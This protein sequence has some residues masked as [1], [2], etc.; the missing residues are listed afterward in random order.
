M[1]IVTLQSRLM[2]HPAF[3]SGCNCFVSTLI[4][5]R[6]P[7]DS[8]CFSDVRSLHSVLQTAQRTS[9]RPVILSRLRSSPVPSIGPIPT[10]DQIINPKPRR[11][12]ESCPSFPI[13]ILT[14]TT[15]SLTTPT[16]AAVH[17]CH[18]EHPAHT[19][20]I[21]PRTLPTLSLN[22]PLF[23]P[24][25]SPLAP[26]FRAASSR[27]R[28]WMR[29]GGQRGWS[30]QLGVGEWV[31]SR[32]RS[33][34]RVG[35]QLH[36]TTLARTTSTMCGRHTHVCEGAGE[37]RGSAG[38]V[39]AGLECFSKHVRDERGCARVCVCI[40]RCRVGGGLASPAC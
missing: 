4:H 21:R 39:T 16:P 29:L 33:G 26:A 37:P 19:S 18:Q 6:F 40:S 7:P 2:C 17:R 31:L 8:Q 27:Y 38:G 14:T 3:S 5:I 1:H 12:G 34:A 23:V 24:L 25:T 30:M 32:S 15:L 35:L 10:T 20:R 36:D 28:D 13:V 9:A 11:G 22:V